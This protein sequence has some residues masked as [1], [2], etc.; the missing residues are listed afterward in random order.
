LNA[1]PPG[2]LGNLPT[3]IYVDSFIREQMDMQT[4]LLV[5][6]EDTEMRLAIVSNFC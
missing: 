3:L 2:L 5:H 6:L 1:A 4:M